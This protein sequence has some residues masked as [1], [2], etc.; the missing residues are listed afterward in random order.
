MICSTVSKEIARKVLPLLRSYKT[1][2][3]ENRLLCV[4]FVS[5]SD[6]LWLLREACQCLSSHLELA[7]LYLAAA[8]SDFYIPAD[9]LVSLIIVLSQFFL[10]KKEHSKITITNFV[11]ITITCCIVLGLVFSYHKLTVHMYEELMS[12]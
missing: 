8:V 1:A 9:K 5:L 4:D 11:E 6:Y 3:A 12:N 7:M 10:K 2:I